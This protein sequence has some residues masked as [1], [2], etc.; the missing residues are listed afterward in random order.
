MTM[1]IRV[2]YKGK[3]CLEQLSDINLLKEDTVSLSQF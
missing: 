2:P 3:K 1:I